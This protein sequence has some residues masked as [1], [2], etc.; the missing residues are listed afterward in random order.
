MHPQPTAGAGAYAA[1]LT[2]GFEAALLEFA[3]G[4]E[5]HGELIEYA[6]QAGHR[7]R[8]VGCL[9]A[10]GAVGG[11]WREAIPVAIGVELLHKSSVVR[12]DI[13]DGDEVRAGQ[14]AFHVAHGVATAVAVSDRLWSMGLAQ[15]AEGAPP[16]VNA[17]C[18]RAAIGVVREMAAGQLEDIA[19]SVQRRGVR[20]R[21]EVEEQKTGSL[22]GLA[23]QMGAMVGGGA[24]HEIA[25]L[26]NFGR[27]IGTAFQ[28]FNDMRNL[29]GEESDRRVASDVRKRRDTVLSAYADEAGALGRP[30]GLEDLD[31]AEVE[32]ARHLLLA[33]GAL[34]FGE[35][36]ASR[37]LD[38]ARAC[39]DA[40]PATTESA[41]LDSLTR[42][43][44][45][46][47]AF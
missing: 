17:E 4:V 12:D 35:E 46:D 47:H 37:L 9:L 27:K 3:E 7:T 28:V 10:C 34:E 26:A 38:E 41:I 18:L 45:R 2:E 22:A 14:A 36:L 44:L 11:D 24:A 40:L 16:P 25:A 19:P 30:P 6:V 29:S 31:D 42:G 15:I 21:A 8:P 32:Q 13:V 23:C 5:S 1:S 33:Q 43:V 39:L 20:A